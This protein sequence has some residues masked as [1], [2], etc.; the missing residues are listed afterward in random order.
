M[1]TMTMHMAQGLGC[2]RRF[3]ESAG[4][5]RQSRNR[6]LLALPLLIELFGVKSLSDVWVRRNRRWLGGNNYI[7]LMNCL[8]AIVGVRAFAHLEI[9]PI[10]ASV[11]DL[12]ACSAVVGGV[13]AVP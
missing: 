1:T 7:L 4:N 2:R 5:I 9:S 11:P 12:A 10:A 6:Q 13:S 3:V 8:K